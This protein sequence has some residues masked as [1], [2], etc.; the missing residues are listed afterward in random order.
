MNPGVQIPK[1]RLE[2][3]PVLRP[4]HA[5]DPRR[6][7]RAD[8]PIR[9]PQAIDVTW[10][11]SAVNRASLSFRATRRTRSRS[12]GALSPALCPG[13]VSPAAFPL[14]DPLPSTVSAAPPWAL[15]DSFA[16]TTDRLTSHDRASRD[17]GLS[18][19]RTTRPTITARAG[20]RGTSRFS[21]MEIPRMH[22]FSDPARSADG[23][24]IT[25]PAMLPSA[26][27]ESVGT[28]TDHF[29]AQ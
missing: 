8:R 26:S 20:D 12:L 27:C 1:V 17:Y 4:R 16:G 10:C 29:G 3:L 7:L 14:A 25:P 2:V 22:R 21:R 9:R 13:R 11:R 24:R 28:P 23:S 15:F 5:V 6:G 18:L 19:P